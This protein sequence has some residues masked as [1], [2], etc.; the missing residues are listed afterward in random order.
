[1]SGICFQK[2]SLDTRV[3]VLGGT[4]NGAKMIVPQNKET[5]QVKLRL[6]PELVERIERLA[7]LAR[8]SFNF[9]ASMLLEWALPHSERE[10]N[11][12]R[13]EPAEHPKRKKQ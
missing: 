11:I 4:T 1:M 7:T 13:A 3:V 2:M 8:Q 9:T 12:E 10:Y 6:E 5:K